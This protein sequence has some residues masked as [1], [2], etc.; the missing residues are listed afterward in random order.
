MIVSDLIVTKAIRIIEIHTEVPEMVL[1]AVL[2][3][4]QVDWMLRP[5]PKMST[6]LP[7]LEK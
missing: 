7:Q 2:L 3:P 4:I 1:I 5:G 6:H